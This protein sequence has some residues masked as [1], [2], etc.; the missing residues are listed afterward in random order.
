MNKMI[1]LL[2]AAAFTCTAS[3]KAPW[4]GKAKK[5]GIEA[6]K[7]CKSCHTSDKASAKDLNDMG[8]WLV[9]QKKA[10]KAE[11]IDLAWLKEYKAKK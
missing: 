7:D 4:V 11:D 10:K 2:V 3:A 1:L 5:L 9:E 6:V 8:K